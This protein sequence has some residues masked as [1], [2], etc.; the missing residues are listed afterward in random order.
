MKTAYIIPNYGIKYSPV[1]TTVFDI[2]ASYKKP[3]TNL[4][5]LEMSHIYI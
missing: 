1:H 3:I 4:F 5:P 2:C